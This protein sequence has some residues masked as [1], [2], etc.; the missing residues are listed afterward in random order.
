MESENNIL[1]FLKR[2]RHLILAV[3]V[4][5]SLVNAFVRF[6]GDWSHFWGGSGITG[7]VHACGLC[8]PSGRLGCHW[9]GWFVQRRE[10]LGESGTGCNR[11]CVLPA[12]IY[13]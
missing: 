2:F 4:I 13:L 8:V 7:M 5:A 11:I 3:M 10:P 12:D 6:A 1:T 9:S